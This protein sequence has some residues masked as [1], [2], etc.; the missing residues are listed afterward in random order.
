M[1]FIM[2]INN[3]SYANAI[4]Y[5]F[6]QPL[7]KVVSKLSIASTIRPWE[8]DALIISRLFIHCV[9]AVVLVVPAGLAWFAG[10][11]ISCLSKTQI[12]HEAIYLAPPPIIAPQEKLDDNTIDI[13]I[14]SRKFNALEISDE[15]KTP[16]RKDCLARMCHWISTQ[17]HQIFPDDENKRKLF[18]K[19]TSI[20]LH[21][22]IRKLENGEVTK[23]KEKDILLELAEGSTRCYPTWLEIAAKID[24]DI[25]G[26]VETVEIKLLKLIQDYKET[27]ILEFTQ[28]ELKTDW[29]G[30]NYVRNILG[31][32]LGLNTNLNI[33]DPH[34]PHNDAVFGKIL[35]KW[36]FLQKYENVNRLI[37][38]IQIMINSQAYDASYHDFLVDIVKQ[39]KIPNPD[40]YVSEKFYTEDY[41]LNL[42]GAN[43]MLKCIGILK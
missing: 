40:D 6:K 27:I 31:V 5:T 22:I 12:D 29:H 3:Y 17:N 32:E 18:C 20:F 26:Q 34:A 11:M 43:L 10:K 37:A 35:T 28:N 16:F 39:Q 33:H 19:Q 42:V 13:N 38:G 24:A 8:S 1:E 41:K 4:G 30:L 2:N 25:N 23:D 14:L 36:L 7:I 21:S 9:I 15:E